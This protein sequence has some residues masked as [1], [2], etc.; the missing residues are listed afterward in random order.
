MDI[1][2]FEEPGLL[3][4]LQQLLE[5]HERKRYHGRLEHTFV[6]RCTINQIGLNDRILRETHLVL[7]E[8][9]IS[10]VP[11]PLKLAGTHS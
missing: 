2:R 10:T 11:M 9:L 6:A 4:I 3:V 8:F 5:S 1:D 7:V